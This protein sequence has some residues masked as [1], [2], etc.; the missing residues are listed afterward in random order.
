LVYS[1]AV[2]AG[3]VSFERKVLE[4]E[5]AWGS[6]DASFAGLV[7]HSEGCIEEVEEECLQVDFA[8]KLTLL[9]TIFAQRGSNTTNNT[10]Q[11]WLVV[12]C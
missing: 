5:P 12:A 4:D 1:L 6:F 11:G 9:I 7:V 10:Y 3:V 8:N 2:P